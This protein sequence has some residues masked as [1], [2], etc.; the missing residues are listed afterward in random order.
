MSKSLRFLL[1][2]FSFAAACNSVTTG[3]DGTITFTPDDCGQAWCSLDDTLA[4]GTSVE[5]T[6]GVVDG[7]DSDVAHL[8]LVSDDPTVA[9]TF[10]LPAAG[11]SRWTVLTT[12]PGVT[13]LVALEGN[14]Y[15]D[16]TLIRAE[17]AFR[18]GLEV[19]DGPAFA[20]DISVGPVTEETWRFPAGE[21]VGFRVRPLDA[22]GFELTGKLNLTTELDQP[23]FDALSGSADVPAGKIALRPMFAGDFALSAYGPEGLVLDVFFEVR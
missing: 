2:S 1:A 10:P 9:V 21:H 3:D 17:R 15:V 16:G 8:T 11:V 5:V 22:H 6:L 19:D 23:L 18:L 14:H 7:F 12:G 13:R 20:G 4:V